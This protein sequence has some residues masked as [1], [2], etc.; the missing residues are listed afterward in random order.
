MTPPLLNKTQFQCLISQKKLPNSKDHMNSNFALRYVR[1]FFFFPNPHHKTQMFLR[2]YKCPVSSSPRS[3]EWTSPCT[4]WK[5]Q[6]KCTATFPCQRGQPCKYYSWALNRKAYR[7]TIPA[8]SCGIERLFSSEQI[9]FACRMARKMLNCAIIRKKAMC[10]RRGKHRWDMAALR[11]ILPSS[12]S[13]K[14]AGA[15][16]GQMEADVSMEVLSKW[17]F[18]WE[19]VFLLSALCTCPCSHALSPG[20]EPSVLDLCCNNLMF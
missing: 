5:R 1:V 19:W 12:V 15:T 2:K 7:N 13:R 17:S 10:P 4:C 8:P 18:A 6:S 11:L 3:L 20:F 9:K 14:G 16:S